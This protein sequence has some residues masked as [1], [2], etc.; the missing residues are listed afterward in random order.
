MDEIARLLGNPTIREGMEQEK[1]LDTAAADE[2]GGPAD[3]N[4]IAFL[5]MG[6]MGSPMARNLAGADWDLVVWNRTRGKAELLTDQGIAVAATAASAASGADVVI[7]ML[8]T[9]AAVMGLLFDR[10]VADAMTPGSIF[11]DMST[12]SP[13]SAI[14]YA[15]EL[16]EREVGWLD[17][18]VSG[19][20]KGA[21][22][23]TLTIMVGGSPDAFA[24]CTPILEKMG[25]VTHVG[26]PGAGQIAKIANQ[27]IVATTIGAVAEALL[28]T[29]SAGLDPKVVR[30]ALIGGFADSRILTEHGRR[31]VDRD[32]V[33]GG[34]VEMQLKDLI[35]ALGE[36]RELNLRL[37]LTEQ[38]TNMFQAM[39]DCGNEEFDHSALILEL[40]RINSGPG[41]AESVELTKK[42]PMP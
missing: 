3:K 4:R 19:G 12:I 6:R 24:R 42:G 29:T 30:N 9:D 40:E 33:P 34:A 7:S 2:A 16:D 13:T 41:V 20:T 14:T 35:I 15:K 11:V 38:V 26:P 10:G 25:R 21:A 22:D 5:G 27:I 8:R 32:F 28:L 1:F 36:A 23:G 37:P 17:A 31:M 39:S 18:P